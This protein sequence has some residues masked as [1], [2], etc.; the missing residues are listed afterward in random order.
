MISKTLF[1]K[2]CEKKNNILLKKGTWTITISIL[3]R[4]NCRK[5]YKKAFMLKIVFDLNGNKKTT[6]QEKNYD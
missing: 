1:R 4:I 3:S 5:S 6:T 2:N